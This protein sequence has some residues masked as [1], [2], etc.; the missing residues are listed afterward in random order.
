MPIPIRTILCARLLGVY[1][2]GVLCSG[3]VFLPAMVVYWVSVPLHLRGI[4]GAVIWGILLSLFVLAFSCV[5]G[6]VVA[7]ISR[8]LKRQSLIT[9]FLS[10]L[11]VIGYYVV[12]AKAQQWFTVFLENA[13]YYGAVF[14]RIYPLYIFGRAGQGDPLCMLLSTVSIFALLGL[15][16]GLRFPNLS[17]TNET[18]KQ[19]GSVLLTLSGGIGYTLLMGG[20]YF[21]LGFGIGATG[22]LRLLCSV[23]AAL[24][25]VLY[26]WLCKKGTALFAA[27]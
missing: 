7:R 8:K 6:Y 26:L 21:L 14:R 9:V 18:V 16:A 15:M 20:G 22:Y 12:Y 27:L 23:N 17:W 5:L 2:T 1:L 24:A 13:Q 10:L 11:F 25:A 4:V 19:S 3:I